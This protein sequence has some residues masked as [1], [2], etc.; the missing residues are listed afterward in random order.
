[1]LRTP[2]TVIDNFPAGC[3]CPAV[4]VNARTS[5]AT[6]ATFARNKCKTNLPSQKHYRRRHRL[7]SAI[8]T[9]IAN[10]PKI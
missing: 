8:A 2:V 10:A 9:A 4:S 7:T 6:A 1:L 3:A 5:A